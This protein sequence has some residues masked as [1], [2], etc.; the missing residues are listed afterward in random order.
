MKISSIL[1]L[2]KANSSIL[3][4]PSFNFKMFILF[5]EKAYEPI[6]VILSGRITVFKLQ[7]MKASDLIQE[8]FL[9]NITSSSLEQSLKLPKPILERLSGRITFVRLIVDKK[10]MHEF[11]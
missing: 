4:S 1:F 9:L 8:R 3:K 6:C 11:L 5:S 7:F 2:E 10:V